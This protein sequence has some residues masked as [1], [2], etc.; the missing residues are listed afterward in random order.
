LSERATRLLER[1]RCQISPIVLLELETL[2]ELGRITQSAKA[3]LGRLSNVMDLTLSDI[4]FQAVVDRALTFAWTR[5]P[6]DRLIVANA[7]A[8]G[9]RL[10]TADQFILANFRDAVW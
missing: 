5:D 7:I 4:S 8:D 10:V 6:F 2:S 9:A 1:E 3:I